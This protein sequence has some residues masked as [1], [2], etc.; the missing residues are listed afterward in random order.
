M[1]SY[2][3][4]W[5]RRLTWFN[6][7]FNRLSL[8][9]TLRIDQERGKSRT[10][11]NY[12]YELMEITEARYGDHLDQLGSSGEK[13]LASA[14]ILKV[15]STEFDNA[16]GMKCK[17]KKTKT[18]PHF[19]AKHLK[20][21]KRKGCGRNSLGDGRKDEEFGFGQKFKPLSDIQ[22]KMS[23]DLLEKGFWRVE[24]WAGGL[25]FGNISTQK[26]KKAI[27]LDVLT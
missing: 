20:V 23:S 3:K 2:W 24:A 11:N 4:I 5:S 27:R 1:R 12:T 13:S 16:F 25:N 17:G 9:A 21:W 18:T 7:H 19:G 10:K 22:I 14:C 15:K 26:V 8:A 6:L